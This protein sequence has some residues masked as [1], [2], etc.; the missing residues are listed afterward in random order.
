MELNI[1]DASSLSPMEC[2]TGLVTGNR[3]LGGEDRR[4]HNS[5]F[6]NEPRGRKPKL[7]DDKVQ[8][9]EKLLCEGGWEARTLPWAA[10]PDAAGVDFDGCGRRYEIPHTLRKPDK[11]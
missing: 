5:D 11:R 1:R 10:L 9:I 6:V 2:P 7:S 8:K 4:L 3:I